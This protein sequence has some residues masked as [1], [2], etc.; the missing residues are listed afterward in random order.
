MH[1]GNYRPLP[2]ADSSPSSSVRQ[3]HGITFE[4]KKNKRGKQGICLFSEQFWSATCA[5]VSWAHLRPFVQARGPST[6]AKIPQGADGLERSGPASSEQASTRQDRA[7]QRHPAVSHVA[8]S[9]LDFTRVT[10]KAGCF[11]THLSHVHDFDGCQL[12]RLDM[13]TLEKR[14]KRQHRR[15]THPFNTHGAKYS[16]ESSSCWVC[17]S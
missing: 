10:N 13:S 4:R 5:R 16:D 6:Q 11:S 12:T 1:R 15:F 3:K 9:P 8:P 17:P 14:E 7:L 2:R